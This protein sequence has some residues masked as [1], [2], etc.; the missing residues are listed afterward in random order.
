[1]THTTHLIALAAALAIAPHTF[2][3]VDEIKRDFGPPQRQVLNAI[4]D[5]KHEP[6]TDRT[7]EDILPR[8]QRR[9]YNVEDYGT[10]LPVEDWKSITW[11]VEG[12]WTHRP[13]T[14]TNLCESCR[15]TSPALLSIHR[16]KASKTALC[17]V[18]GAVSTFMHKRFAKMRLQ[19]RI[20][21]YSRKDDE[22]KLLKITRFR[23]QCLAVVDSF[24]ALSSSG[25]WEE[26]LSRKSKRDKEGFTMGK[27][28][29]AQ[30]PQ[31]AKGG[32]DHP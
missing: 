5:F 25:E 17:P 9:F 26:E 29:P 18:C 6:V 20:L 4:R 31:D 23:N 22:S 21:T 28:Q 11:L 27:P 13:E 32:A 8:K 3:Q 19:Y 10:P 16:W 24:D 12:T 15:N 7:R 30:P 1:M 2:A 14:A